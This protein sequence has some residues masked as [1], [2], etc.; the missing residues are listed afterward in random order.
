MQLILFDYERL[1]GQFYLLMFFRRLAAGC[2]LPVTNRAGCEFQFDGF[3]D[4]AFIK[5]RAQVLRMPFLSA[6]F[7]RAFSFRLFGRFDDIR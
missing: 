7:T 3:V 1:I 2:Q 6:Y 4:L 5:R